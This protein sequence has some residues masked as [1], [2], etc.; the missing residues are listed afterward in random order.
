MALRDQSS[1]QR[2]R[3]YRKL[4]RQPPTEVSAEMASLP[5]HRQRMLRPRSRTFVQLFVQFLKLIRG[6]SWVIAAALT[7]LTVST[8]LGLVPMY[9]MKLV[10]DHVLGNHPP[11]PKLTH[12]VTLPSDRKLL[13]GVV[14]GGMILLTLV[15]LLISTWGRWHMTRLTKRVQVSVRRRVFDHAVQLPLH[16][17][18]ELKS[19]GV[20]SVLRDDAGGVADLLFSMIY[21]PWRAIIQLVGTL[22]ILTLTDWRLLIGSLALLPVVHLTHRTWISRIRPLFR[23]IRATRTR[24]DGHATEVFAGMRVV[25]GFSRQRTE[26]GAFSRNNHLMARQEIFAWWWSR[27]VD[28]AWS[29]LIPTASAVLLWYGGVRILN[30]M[31]R[32]EAGLITPREALTIGDLVM[33]LGYLASL[34]GPLATLAG[35]AAG[36]QNN[37]AALDRVLD[38]LAEPVEMPSKPT[39][40]TLHRSGVAGRIELRQVGFTYPRNTVPV[41][42][43]IN[44]NVKPGQVVALVGPSGAG[45][46]T[47]CN[48]IA[49]FYDPTEGAILLD[50]V[51]LRDIE[52]RSYRRHLGIV[53]QD[54]FLFD[55]TVGQNIAYS[56]RDATA[57]QIVQAAARANAD[58]FIRQLPQ[59]YDTMIGE[60]GVRLSGG[61]R[62][63]ISIARAILADPRILI[64]D[65]A[66]SNLDTHSEQLI[67]AAL[68]ELYRDRTT[69][70]I[71]HR[72]STVRHADLIVVLEHGRISETGT[73]EQLMAAEGVYRQMVDR[74]SAMP[75]DLSATLDQGV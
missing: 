59:G 24:V 58:E 37:L 28:I 75:F 47:L 53:E 16:R 42:T 68:T 7:T 69:F 29:V 60:R 67:Q 11:S 49:R 48:L 23:D 10:F 39:A 12:W 71:A 70:V 26:A 52:V 43:D 62:Q 72:L 13:L 9:G 56:R 64:L 25:R 36:L 1:H 65:E 30:D 21:N 33:F 2:F 46:T 50:G 22:I 18:V 6:H 40:R 54:V 4:L 31:A 19:G 17:V 44:L 55:G 32:L 61:Q 38:L 73:H 27:G 45:K 51:D 57:D 41:L 14:A 5:A 74:Q 15:S 35:S 63:R 3:E 8:L 66:T 34:L 20:A